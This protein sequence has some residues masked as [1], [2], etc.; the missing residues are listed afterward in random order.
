MTQTTHARAKTPRVPTARTDKQAGV[1]LLPSAYV[2][3]V[4]PS[5]CRLSAFR[6]KDATEEQIRQAVAP[7][8]DRGFTVRVHRD[9][10]RL[11]LHR[12]YPE[13]DVTARLK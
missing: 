9:P 2:S 7:W 8:L 12:I 1:T 4:T 10:A 3:P 5:G 13:P 11:V 6:L